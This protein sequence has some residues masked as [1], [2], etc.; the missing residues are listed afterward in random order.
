MHQ[1]DYELIT[2]AI[3]DAKRSV[4]RSQEDPFGAMVEYLATRLKADN[5][6]FDKGKFV[7]AC[8]I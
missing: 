4:A 2:A 1:Q 6:R 8:Q 3:R 7:K 5:A